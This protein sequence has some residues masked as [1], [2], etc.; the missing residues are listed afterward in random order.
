MCGPYVVILVN[1]PPILECYDEIELG[2]QNI[3]HQFI[4]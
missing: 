3:K 2:V 1:W 4:K